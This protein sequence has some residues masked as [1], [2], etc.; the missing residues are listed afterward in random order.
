MNMLC[1]SGFKNLC[2]LNA[3]MLNLKLPIG[4]Q[5]MLHIKVML[6]ITHIKFNICM[7]SSVETR[8]YCHHCAIDMGRWRTKMQ[9]QIDTA[10]TIVV[11]N[12]PKTK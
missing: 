1:S 6:L 3:Q 4:I 8:T 10:G 7:C 2:L 11:F 5:K 9:T 12:N